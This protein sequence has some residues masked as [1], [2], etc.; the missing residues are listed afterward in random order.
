V[1]RGFLFALVVLFAGQAA[2]AQP[3]EWPHGDRRN[4][5]HLRILRDYEL[6]AGS[7]AH[8]PIVVI[9]A[10]ATINGRAEDG[11]VVIGGSLRVGPTAI[12][13]G[14]V[15]AVGGEAI[16]DPA[17]QIAGTVDT[18]LIVGP[19]FDLAI[20]P[21]VS[22]W[23]PAFAFGAT[24][25]R[26]GLVLIV[27]LLLTVVAPDWIRGISRRAAASPLAAAGVGV[28]GQVLFVPAVVAV[29][30]AL[31]VSIIG[32][33]VLFTFPFLMGAAALLWVAGFTA[34][35]INL[36]SALRGRGLSTYRPPAIDLLIGFFAITAVTLIAQAMAFTPGSFGPLLWVVRTLGWLI[37][38]M[39][40]TVGLGA[41]LVALLGS[42]QPAM[43][44]P[45]PLAT[46]LPSRG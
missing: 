30:V 21:F 43:P 11:V 14:D 17:A 44:P 7:T 2:S 27:A 8:E 31:I 13:R 40:W 1:T 24:L 23:W 10:S 25:L 42:R 34:V 18:T 16:V 32:I 26:L 39:A 20:G 22:G 33:L 41:A 36:G 35:A 3:A 38:W 5:V 19:D 4:G 46:P 29:T 45:M 12:V 28:T 9:G 37:E 6:P 15:V